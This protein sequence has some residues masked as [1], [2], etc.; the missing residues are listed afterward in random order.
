MLNSEL[1]YPS[2]PTASY[3][4]VISLICYIKADYLGNK[5]FI[6]VSWTETEDAPSIT[7]LFSIMFRGSAVC[8]I[9]QKEHLNE[10]TC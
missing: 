10:H 8:N 5:C 7:H 2:D 6:R 1:P 9:N 4:T 3:G